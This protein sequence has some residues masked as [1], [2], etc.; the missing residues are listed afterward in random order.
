VRQAADELRAAAE[1]KARDLRSAAEARADDL[2]HRAE[3]YYDEARNRARTLQDDGEA[4][5]RENPMRAVVMSLGAGF[6][7]GLMFRR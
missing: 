7:L 2:R 3:D 4:Y 1:A 5:V 6:I